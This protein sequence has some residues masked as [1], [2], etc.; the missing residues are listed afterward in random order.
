MEKAANFQV[1]TEENIV[2]SWENELLKHVIPST[3]DGQ[4]SSEKNVKISD[5]NK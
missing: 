3:A 4:S 1:T 2:C 5:K